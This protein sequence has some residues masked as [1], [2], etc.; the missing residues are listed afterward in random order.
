MIILKKEKKFYQVLKSLIIYLCEDLRG[1][2]S[3]FLVDFT[4]IY[5]PR[6]LEEGEKNALNEL[7]ENNNN[8]RFYNDAFSFLQ[9]LM[10][11]IIKENY[12]KNYLK[13]TYI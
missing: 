5:N 3:S 12:N 2:N 8:I 7:F 4:N 11:E 1:E 6:V 13:G 9:I 10:N